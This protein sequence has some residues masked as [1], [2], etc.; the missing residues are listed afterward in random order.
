[1]RSAVAVV[2]LAL[3]SSCADVEP[4]RRDAASFLRELHELDEL[5][6]FDPRTTELAAGWD[7]AGGN[8]MDGRVFEGIEGNTNLLLDVEGPGCIHRISTGDLS[9]VA[10]TRIEIRLDHEE[11]PRIAMPVA[12]F[13]DPERSPFG[14]PLV[15]VGTYPTIRMPIP[16]TEHAEVRLIS[17]DDVHD[18]GLF[19]QI[20]YSRYPEGTPVESLAMPLDGSTQLAIAEL[21]AS[22]DR[23]LVGEPRAHDAPTAHVAETLA[24]GQTTSWS[25]SGPGTIERLELRVDPNWPAAWRWLRLRATWDDADTP[26]IDLPVA[27]LLGCDHGDD[28]E[29]E[30]D[31]LLLGA[32]GG[33]SYLRLPMPYREGARFELI[34]EGPLAIDVDLRLWRDPTLPDVDAG[35]LH[36]HVASAPAATESSPRSGPMQVPVHRLFESEGRGKLVGVILRVDWPYAGWWGEGDWQIW[37]D[38]DFAEWPPSYHGTGTEEFFDSGWTVFDR[39]PLAGEIKSRPGLATVFAFMLND[40][41]VWEHNV[42]VQVETMGLGLANE[43]VVTEH[44][45]WTSTVF[46]YAYP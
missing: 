31:S 7:P 17:D 21:T 30:F 12:E 25:E 11:Q 46:W 16:F 13:F 32:H 36:A 19:W 38:Q 20:G 39:K 9:M 23:A 28:P 6:R 29:T 44:P 8:D 41:V 10:G 3:V 27:E 24:P 33:W 5:P 4:P 22:W 35:T 42:R 15:R 14:A 2:G 45:V 43:V 1:M 37:V 34:N 40:A 18:W 26:A